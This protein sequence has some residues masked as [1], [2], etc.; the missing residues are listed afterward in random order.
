MSR[1]QLA[2]E[3]LQA[4][5]RPSEVAGMARFGINP[6]GRLGLS[7]PAMRRIAKTLG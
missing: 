1:L 6:E 7:V 4:D 2:L 5:A 3:L